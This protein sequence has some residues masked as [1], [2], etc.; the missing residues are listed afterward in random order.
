LASDA[1]GPL[2]FVL[3]LTMAEKSDKP[4]L[5]PILKVFREAKG[6]STDKIRLFL[7]IQF[8]SMVDDSTKLADAGTH[9]YSG[10]G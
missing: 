2:F 3:A 4:A 8:Y 6:S 7:E 5:L 9:D 1:K 10:G